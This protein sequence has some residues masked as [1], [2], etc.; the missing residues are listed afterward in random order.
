M[1]VIKLQNVPGRVVITTEYFGKVL[2]A[3]KTNDAKEVQMEIERRGDLAAYTHL[4][5]NTSAHS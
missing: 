4:E 3:A 1:F 2:S 5:N